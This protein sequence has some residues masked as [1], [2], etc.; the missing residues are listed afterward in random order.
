MIRRAVENW[1]LPP[2]VVCVLKT[3]AARMRKILRPAGYKKLLRENIGLKDRH[4]GTRCFI[5]GAGSSVKSQDIKKLAGEIVLTV[6]NTFVHPDYPFVKPKY[7]IFPPVFESHGRWYSVDKFVAWLKAAD[8][9]TFDAEIFLCIGDKEMCDSHGLFK[10]RTVHWVD[11]L[12]WSWR[13]STPVDLSTIPP[14]WTVSETALTIALYLGFDK[15]YLLGFDHDW[16]N[17]PLVYFYDES[18]DHVMQPSRQALI[19]GGVDAEFQMRRHADVFRKYKYLYSK[20]QNIFNANANP[21]HYLDVFPK[22]EFNSLF[23]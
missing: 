3:A 17:G 21:F 10:E 6:S 23:P 7:H 8:E 13:M 19:E 18:K 15:I 4:K 9:N 14:I 20:K 22:V 2:G 11:Y 12:P 1:M 5:L 16:F